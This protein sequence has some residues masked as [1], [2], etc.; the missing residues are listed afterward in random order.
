MITS[1]SSVSSFSDTSW[2]TSSPAVISSASKVSVTTTSVN[3]S[4]V[5]AKASF[6]VTKVSSGAVN[7][8]YTVK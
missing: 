3:D 5:V 2:S 4:L 7:G 6:I 1:V 8:N